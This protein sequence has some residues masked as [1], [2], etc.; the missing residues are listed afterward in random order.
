M[1][2]SSKSFD[3]LKTRLECI[4]IAPFE[5]K[6]TSYT[7]NPCF[8]G[9]DYNLKKELTIE[10]CLREFDNNLSRINEEKYIDKGD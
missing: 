4:K 5:L 3:L 2:P 7:N 8:F 9:N 1:L 10:M 6:M